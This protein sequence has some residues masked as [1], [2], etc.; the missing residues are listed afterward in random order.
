M[1]LVNWRFYKGNL[2]QWSI[3]IHQQIS[4]SREPLLIAGNFFWPLCLV[5]PHLFQTSVGPFIHS[6][7]ILILI[8]R[9]H[10]VED[11]NQQQKKQMNSAFLVY[12]QITCVSRCTTTI[13]KQAM[14]TTDKSWTAENI[15]RLH[16]VTW[17]SATISSLGHKN[18][19]QRQTSRYSK[20]PNHPLPPSTSIQQAL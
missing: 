9:S 11:V 12:C 3:S 15:L 4:F 19:K 17:N 18:E 5:H 1:A 16:S 20:P 14:R 10:A 2:L 7:G 6:D 8:F 13:T